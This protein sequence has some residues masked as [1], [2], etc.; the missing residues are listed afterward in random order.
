MANADAPFGFRPIGS[1]GGPYSG[2]TRRCQISSA[3]SATAIFVGDAVKLDT[4]T[5]NAST[6]GY[7]PV[8]I[9]SVGDAVYGVV[10]SFEADPTDLG[11]QYRK[12]STQRFCH[13]ALAHNTLFV[14]QDAGTLGIAGI[15]ANA[16]YNKVAG[17]T[18][19]GFAKGEL[20]STATASTSD[21]MII[22]GYDAPDNDI[23]LSNALFVVKF[24]DPQT[25]PRRIGV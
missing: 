23:T 25:R 7:Q 14:I 19:T 6:G 24:L 18:V 11:V 12:A 9:A 20:G 2:V 21:C 17:S 15:G 4:D 5:T 1:D 16:A 13:V 3:N 22:G 8:D 10:T